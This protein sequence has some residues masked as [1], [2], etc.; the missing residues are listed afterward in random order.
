VIKQLEAF[1]LTPSDVSFIVTDNASNAQGG[2][3]GVLS[4][5]GPGGILSFDASQQMRKALSLPPQDRLPCISHTLQL[6]ILDAIKSV[7]AVQ[8][9]VDK[10]QKLV[11]TIRK[12]HVHTQ[13]LKT[14]AAQHNDQYTRLSH[15]WLL[16][17]LAGH[18][19]CIFSIAC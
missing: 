17:L 9:L 2:A 12:S 6:W 15:S 10:A 16:L 3:R 4:I 14:L 11:V 19:R 18:R 8:L 1:S 7:E 5:A 13:A